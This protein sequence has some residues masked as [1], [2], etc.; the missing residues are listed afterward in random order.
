MFLYVKS[1]FPLILDDLLINNFCFVDKLSRHQS[2]RFSILSNVNVFF[3]IVSIFPLEMI[4]SDCYKYG[5][6]Q[7]GQAD[8]N[9]DCCLFGHGVSFK[10][11]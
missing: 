6:D 8:V 3:S 9:S 4:P 7:D 1:L 11:P 10:T 2:N 5:P